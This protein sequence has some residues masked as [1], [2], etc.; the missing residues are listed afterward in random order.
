MMRKPQH[1]S[2]RWVPTFRAAAAGV[3]LLSLAFPAIAFAQFGQFGGGGFSPYGSYYP[4][5]TSSNSN[6]SDNLRSIDSNIDQIIKR[7]Q[8][9]LQSTGRWFPAPQGNDMQ[10][11]MGLQT[12]KQQLNQIRRRAGG[13]LTPELQMQLSQL[14]QS[15]SSLV[16]TMQRAGIDPAT[17]G[18]MQMLQDSLSRTI[19]AA[20]IT[21]GG[22]PQNPFFNMGQPYPNAFGNPMLNL[23]SIGRGEL[24]LMGISFMKLRQIS[25]QTIDP[26]SKRVSAVFS[27][28]RDSLTLSGPIAQQTLNS[29][30]INVDSSDKGA[31]SGSLN[32]AFDGNG[33][34]G[35]VTGSGQMNGQPYAIRFSN[36]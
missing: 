19:A 7:V 27:G 2:A 10:I 14:Q 22:T 4:S 23:S 5:A 20:S 9:F 18:Q 32:I 21:P 13:N 16:G 33:S 26:V 12:F 8:T 17:L 31:T 15:G 6:L 28:G 35:M 24:T 1:K 34:V 11:C 25:V 30:V 36:R 29:L 3:S